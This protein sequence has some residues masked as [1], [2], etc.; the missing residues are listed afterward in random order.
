MKP[1]KEASVQIRETEKNMVMDPL[2][3]R[4]TVLAKTSSN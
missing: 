3:Q 2:Q 4:I 1:Q